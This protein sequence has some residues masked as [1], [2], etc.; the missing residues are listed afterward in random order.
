[1]FVELVQ[2]RA[3]DPKRLQAAWD[4]TLGVIADQAVGWW[5]ATSGVAADGS[6]V[7]FLGF[8][9]EEAARITMDRL[10]SRSAWD[11]V[12]PVVADSTFRECPNT[13]AFTVRDP[14]HADYAHVTQGPA[15]DISRV[16][17]EFERLSRARKAERGVI[18]GLLCWDD[19]G[20]ASN[21]L[22]RLSSEAAATTPATALWRDAAELYDQPVRFD[23]AGPWS[24]FT[25]PE[26]SP[27]DKSGLFDEPDND[28]PVPA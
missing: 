15:N 25:G 17:A 6:F 19:A 23:L 22:Y 24:V 1:M 13:R 20:F 18:G 16:V 11:Q 4:Q 3:I 12:V 9:S 27:R 8:A 21:V 14:R 10:D 2:G 28:P 7:A 26:P 5:G